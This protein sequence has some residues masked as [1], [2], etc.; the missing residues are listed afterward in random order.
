MRS[1][2]VVSVLF[3]LPALVL[4]GAVLADNFPSR[5]VRLIVPFPPGGSTDLVARVA[6][7][8]A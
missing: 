4:S 6:A 7:P 2:C 3:F 5:P 1:R 8:T